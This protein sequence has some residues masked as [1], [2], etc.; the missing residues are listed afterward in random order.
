MQK[1]RGV[2]TPARLALCETGLELA[3]DADL[4][5]RGI[6]KGVGDADRQRHRR[7]GVQPVRHGETQRLL[8]AIGGE[9]ELIAG[10]AG[11]RGQGRAT[12]RHRRDGAAA[13]L[14]LVLIDQFVQR[15]LAGLQ[16]GDLP[17]GR[18]KHQ[19]AAPRS[20]I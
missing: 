6:T 20:R 9:V 11:R 14:G 15:H 12:H 7:L 16:L 4:D 2:A 1:S 5:R 17:A 3:G 8:V 13:G 19:I 18:G 10:L